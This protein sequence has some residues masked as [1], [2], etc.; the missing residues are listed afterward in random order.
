M[1]SLLFGVPTV[2]SAGG[3]SGLLTATAVSASAVLVL[4][5][6]VV[7]PRCLKYLSLHRRS[8]PLGGLR[9]RAWGR[10]SVSAVS[11]L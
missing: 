7:C 5:F 4:V 6:V 2:W 10:M 11:H 9:F 8:F 3:F 1:M